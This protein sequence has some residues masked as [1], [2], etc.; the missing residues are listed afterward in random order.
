[1]IKELIYRICFR[2]CRTWPGADRSTDHCN[3]CRRLCR[4]CSRQHRTR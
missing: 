3:V 1:M 2:C 4:M